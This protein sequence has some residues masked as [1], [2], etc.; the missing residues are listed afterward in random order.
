LIHNKFAD[1][2]IWGEIMTDP[3]DIEAMELDSVHASTDGRRLRL[4]VRDQSGRTV[5]LT[6]PASWL[7]SM[8]NALPRSDGG[9]VVHPLDSW[10]LDRTSNGQDLVLTLQTP[11]GNAVSFAMKRWQVEGMATIATYGSAAGNTQQT[12]H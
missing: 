2:N 9:G 11:E 8:L 10:S 6:L 7:N 12:V 3:S 5:R 4:R 1:F